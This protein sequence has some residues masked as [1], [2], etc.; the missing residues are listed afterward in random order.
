MNV[1]ERLYML[2]SA[3][4]LL[5]Q[6]ATLID[7]RAASRDRPAE[8]SMRAA[9][10]AF[11]VLTTQ[12]LTELQ[13]WIFMAVLKI[14][15]AQAGS[16]NPDDYLDGAAYMALALEHALGGLEG[17][18]LPAANEAEPEVTTDH[19]KASETSEGGYRGRA[20]ILQD[21]KS[22]EA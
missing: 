1:E 21:W 10:Q 16:L 15:R 19:G 22:R 5:R 6:A 9:V 7:Q 18:P 13:G 17:D 12:S 11:N 2:F 8:R 4:D 3:P 14:A 20:K